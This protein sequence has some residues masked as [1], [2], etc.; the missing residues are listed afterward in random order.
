MR[1]QWK[2]LQPMVW[3]SVLGVSL[4][5]CTILPSVPVT[6]SSAS[7]VGAWMIQD[8]TG[9]SGIFIAPDSTMTPLTIQLASGKLV[10]DRSNWQGTITHISYDSL[11]IRFNRRRLEP[12]TVQYAVKSNKLLL[13]NSSHSSFLATKYSRSKLGAQ[14]VPPV[15]ATLHCQIDEYSPR[16][17]TVVRS[18]NWQA[19]TLA[20]ALSAYA[21]VTKHPHHRTLDIIGLFN[22]RPSIYAHREIQWTIHHFSGPGTYSVT[23]DSLVTAMLGSQFGDAGSFYSTAWD[24]AGGQV[25]IRQYDTSTRRCTGTFEFTIYRRHRIRITV[26]AGTFDVPI[27]VP[28]QTIYQQWNYGK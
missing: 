3:L 22:H 1:L 15:L 11:E 19:D 23:S 17:Q 2:V 18:F 28:E 20:P 13:Q 26:T 27:V 21:R 25:T 5:T 4:V 10:R 8:S 14:V 24:S 16:V 12:M 6:P 9:V 7:L